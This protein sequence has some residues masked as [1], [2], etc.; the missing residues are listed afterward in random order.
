MAEPR[1]RRPR[2]KAA[3]APAATPTVASQPL[4]DTIWREVVEL[5]L[6]AHQAQV[7][8]GLLRLGTATIPQLGAISQVSEVNI[9]RALKELSDRH[10]AEQLPTQ[11]PML[12]TTRGR[13]AV[14]RQL[15]VAAEDQL[16]RHRDRAEHVRELLV[17]TVDE[18]PSLA[19]PYVRVVRRPAL[20]Q[21]IYNHML[22]AT[23]AELLNFTRPPYASA[24]VNPLV[25]QTLKRGVRARVL[26][27]ADKVDDPTIQP[28]LRAYHRAGVEGRLLD[29]LPMK[30]VISDRK[31]V[32]LSL[33][34]PVLPE[35]GYPTTL[36]IEHPPYAELQAVAF[37]QLWASGR[38]F[39]VAVD[40]EADMAVTPR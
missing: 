12:W 32:L 29:E 24:K 23:R 18:N 22:R 3:P 8:V 17:D 25:L 6:T 28:W 40:A 36:H 14:L 30:L 34:H 7:L 15:T 9:Y 35:V 33:R 26:Y 4:P 10:L 27:Q 2:S 38:A 11:R 1:V 37:E 31:S 21:E 16:R 20:V 5:G 13:D 19:V 39:S